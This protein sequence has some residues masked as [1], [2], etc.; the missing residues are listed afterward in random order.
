VGKYMGMAPSTKVDLV[1][2]EYEDSPNEV[3]NQ[4]TRTG[5]GR[6]GGV[7]SV[8]SDPAYKKG[9]LESVRG[10]KLGGGKKNFPGAVKDHRKNR[11][12]SKKGGWSGKK[13]LNY[14]WKEKF[15]T[16]CKPGGTWGI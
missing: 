8:T 11:D 14:L 3:K 9:K 12:G 13:V 2:G 10:G 16:R 4:F 7:K 5:W 6:V 15:K 1:T